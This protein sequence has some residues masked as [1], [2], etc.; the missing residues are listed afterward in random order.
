MQLMKREI[1]SAVIL[2]DL[3]DHPQTLSELD[4]EL[5]SQGISPLYTSWDDLISGISTGK[6][7]EPFLLYQSAEMRISEPRII[8]DFLKNHGFA[9]IYNGHIPIALDPKKMFV[10]SYRFYS[11][12]NSTDFHLTSETTMGCVSFQRPNI[13]APRILMHTGQ[14]TEYFKLTLNS[15][16]HS[17]VDHS[18]PISILLNDSPKE[19]E[20]VALVALNKYPNI[21]I[22]R[23]NKNPVYAGI[24]ILLQYYNRPEK[25]I[26][27]EDDIILPEIVKDFFPHWPYLFA[28]R[29]DSLNVVG[30][31]C[32]TSN[33][34]MDH[35]WPIP[36]TNL[37]RGWYHGSHNLR[38]PIMGQCFAT[39]FTHYMRANEPGTFISRDENLL[40]KATLWAAPFIK[41]Y[42]IG[43]NQRMD[44]EPRARD[45]ISYIFEVSNVV[46]GESKTIDIRRI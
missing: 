24:N 26:A 18:V 38:W 23:C 46:T 33:R 25:F 19:S 30:W 45:E 16:L 6:F 3:Y 12:G 39:T 7:V 2:H 31:M 10:E 41:P 17:L 35:V 20:D 34:P 36:N 4:K 42:H 27:M 8:L 14:R 5:H 32:D 22:L 43:W 9:A 11:L 21:E 13:E 29:L 28:Q 15:L 37:Q 1:N 44:Y 40:R